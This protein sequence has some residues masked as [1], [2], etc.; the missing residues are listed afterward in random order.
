[1]C[2]S[3]SRFL[4]FSQGAVVGSQGTKRPQSALS[5]WLLMGPWCSGSSSVNWDKWS[6]AKLLS[7]VWLCDPVDCSLPGS[8]IHGILQARIL[9][10]VAISFSRG[11]SW[12]RDR[13]WVSCIA[14]RRFTV[15]ATREALKI[16]FTC[17]A[18]VRL[19]CKNSSQI[20]ILCQPLDV[21]LGFSRDR[22][23]CCFSEEP[24]WGTAYAL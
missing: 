8:W 12:P 4:S 10:W 14:D 7:R 22:T 24:A 9:E 11:S 6:E 15:W 20:L 16:W 17:W 3:G 19:T 5:V 23:H 18:V 2:L 1:M 13:T 21:R